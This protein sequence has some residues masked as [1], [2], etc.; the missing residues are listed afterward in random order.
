[1]TLREKT[2]KTL[3]TQR[4]R[5]LEGKVNS[6]PHLFP[7]FT[8]AFP[9]VQRAKYYVVTAN[10]KVGK[11][12]FTNYFFVFNLILYAFKHPDKLKLKI[13]YFNLE[14][15]E[16]VL[17][18]RFIS[19]L[20]FLLSGKKLVCDS[21]ELL[22]N[23]N[24]A[25]SEDILKLLDTSPYREILDFY[26]QCL[27]FRSERHPTGIKIAIDNH[28]KS[29]GIIHYKYIAVSNKVTGDLEQMKVFDY[30]E[31]Y[32]SEELFLPIYDHIGLIQPEQGQTLKQAIDDI[33][34]YNVKIRN[35]FGSSPVAVM[36][37]TADQ[38]SVENFKYSKLK[39]T[40]SGLADSKYPGRDR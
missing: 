26:E 16:E 31:P 40:A 19:Y 10:Q 27:E 24:I 38:E 22:S 9:G 5:I 17:Y 7:R 25:I 6:I 15:S 30:Y 23:N 4:T 12:Q 32:D 34:M 20:L 13:M 8:K 33:S 1:M 37:Q 21:T 3:V 18:I 39:P 29:R 36:Q 2:L 35:R 11:S 14:E 28:I